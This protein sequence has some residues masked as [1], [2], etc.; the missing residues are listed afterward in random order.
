MG[1]L[2]YLMIVFFRH[3]NFF[4]YFNNILREKIGAIATHGHSTSTTSL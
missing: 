3:V 2:E 4:M 1:I